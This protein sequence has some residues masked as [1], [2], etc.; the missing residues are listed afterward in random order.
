[1]QYNQY[2]NVAQRLSQ[3]EPG[4]PISRINYINNMNQ[5]MESS[6]LEKGIDFIDFMNGNAHELY[7]DAMVQETKAGNTTKQLYDQNSYDSVLQK[8]QQSSLFGSMINPSTNIDDMEVRLPNS[9]SEKTRM[10]RRKLFFEA[11]TKNQ[12]SYGG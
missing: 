5:L 7:T 11:I 4:I 3:Q 2:Q 9:I 10:E 6:K 1:M 8:H 12:Q